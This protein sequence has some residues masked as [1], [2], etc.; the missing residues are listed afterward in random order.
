MN[1][2]Q[3]AIPPMTPQNAS[4]AISSN[5]PAFNLSSN[6]MANMA[7]QMSSYYMGT[8]QFSASFQQQQQ[9]QQQEQQR[10]KQEQLQFQQQ[11]QLQQQQQQLQ[12]QQFQQQLLQQQS[13]NQHSVAMKNPAFAKQMI[14][15]IMLDA[16]AKKPIIP[17]DSH[18]MR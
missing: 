6:E 14:N 8:N 3:N 9:R 10:Q 15:M 5:F 1:L 4:S 11:Q 7:N 18:R 13:N 17:M 12:Q 16:A 2:Q